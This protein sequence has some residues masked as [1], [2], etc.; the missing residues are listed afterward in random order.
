MKRSILLAYQLLAGLSD[1]LTGAMLIAEPVLALRWMGLQAPADAVPFIAY[2]G[3]FV[4][5]VGLCYLYG[6]MLLVRGGCTT[7]LEATWLLTAI[8]RTSV[9]AFVFSSVLVGT[10]QSGWITVALFDGAC[11]L[12]QAIGLRRGWLSDV[13]R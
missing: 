8:F 2:I 5:A 13:S 12:I 1:A 11:A 3:S 7:K 6:A 9:A 10:L 4:L